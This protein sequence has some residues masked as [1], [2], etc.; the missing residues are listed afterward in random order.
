MHCD[1]TK[2]L[3]GAW[4]CLD[5]YIETHHFLIGICHHGSM[6]ISTISF[7]SVPFDLMHEMNCFLGN[8]LSLSKGSLLN[9]AAIVL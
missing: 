9:V 3:K 2:G 5:Q 6:S 8:R 4:I 7:G 1:R